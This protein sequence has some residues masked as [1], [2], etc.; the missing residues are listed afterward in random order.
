MSLINQIILLQEVDNKLFEIEKLLGDLPSK[1]QELT[2][3]EDNVK[4]SLQNKENELKD[5]SVSISSNET[6]VRTT[7]E[8]IN[9]LKDKLIDGSISTNKEYDAMMETIDFEKNLLSE[10]ENELIEL[11]TK[12]EELAKEIEDDKSALDG[13][14]TELISKKDALNAKMQEVSEE[15]NAL[16]SERESVTKNVDADTMSKYSE[17]Y[18][19]RKGLVVAEILDNSCEGCGAMVPPQ[20][21]NEAIAKNIVFCGNCSRFLYKSEN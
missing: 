16:K 13:I 2:Q 20:S 11:M 4:L 8:K 3:N 21:I 15:Q 14:I 7:S 5:T 10:K 18:K 9:S 17:I 12:K 1:V 6:L 19:A